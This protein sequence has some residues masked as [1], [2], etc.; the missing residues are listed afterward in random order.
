MTKSMMLIA[1]M[2]IVIIASQRDKDAEAFELALPYGPNLNYS[3]WW[4][5]GIAYDHEAHWCWNTDGE[6]LEDAQFDTLGAANAWTNVTEPYFGLVY[7]GEC[8]QGE[9]PFER[10]GVSAVTVD[11]EPLETL[12][13]STDFQTWDSNTGE[14]S[15]VDIWINSCPDVDPNP[16]G[17]VYRTM[18]HEF[19]HFIGLNNHGI[20]TDDDEDV[21][22]I[23]NPCGEV[24][25][26]F[27]H[28]DWNTPRTDD[29]NGVEFIYRDK[30]G[31]GC[32]GMQEF[33]P[34][35]QYGGGI[36]YGSLHREDNATPETPW[37]SGRVKDFGDVNGSQ[38]VTITDKSIVV[39]KFGQLIV[40][41]GGA[42]ADILDQDGN[43]NVSATD[44]A[45]VE[46]QIGD[47][48]LVGP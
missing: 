28:W 31:D 34:L 4:P 9:D 47:H 40:S 15:E 27:C 2:A 20:Y 17:G 48:C 33:G 8:E 46:A 23:F 14:M 18:I 37:Y 43:G 44:V 6:E 39:S 32:T 42:A 35:S 30:D 16:S 36:A 1:A 13:A 3:L 41:N 45:R 29:R 24:A 5:A 11:C 7:D 26:V 12:L 25:S 19:G 10:D 21:A 22:P 38:N